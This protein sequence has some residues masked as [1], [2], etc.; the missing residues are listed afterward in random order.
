MQRCFGNLSVDRK[1]ENSCYSI[2]PA[3]VDESNS[4]HELGAC[5]GLFALAILLVAAADLK[6]IK[7]AGQESANST[8]RISVVLSRKVTIIQVYAS[9]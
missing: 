8:F 5:R 3:V 6:N 4:L 2:S 7:E 1:N 9:S